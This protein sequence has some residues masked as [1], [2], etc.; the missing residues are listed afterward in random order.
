MNKKIIFLFFILLICIII[1][2]QITYKLSKS[3]NNINKSDD[4]NIFN[5]SSYEAIIEVEVHSNKNTNK[6]ILKQKFSEP[7]IFKQEVIKPEN[8]EGLTTIFDGKNLTLENSSLNLKTLYENYNGIEGNS[9]SLKSFMDDYKK[10]ENPEIEELENE[11]IINIKINDNTNKY[12]T[13]KKLYINKH[14][15]LPIKMEILDINQNTTVYILYKEIKVNKTS[16][17][18]VLAK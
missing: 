12:E 17:D 8:I 16:K 15:K 2:I 18:E 3:G 5:I 14:T 9:F 4:N 13:Y 11:Q 7:N 10:C 6:Y 1:F